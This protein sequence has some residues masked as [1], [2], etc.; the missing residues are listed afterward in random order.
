MAVDRASRPQKHPRTPEEQVEAN[1][2]LLLGDVFR[3]RIVVLDIEQGVVRLVPNPLNHVL[4][5][6]LR[7]AGLEPADDETRG[8]PIIHRTRDEAERLEVLL[9]LIRERS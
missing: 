1:L 9:R 4:D 6:A 2:C 5:L 8:L 7:H 3:R